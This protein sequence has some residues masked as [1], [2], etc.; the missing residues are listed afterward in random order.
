M[1]VRKLGK[2]KYPIL[3][4]MHLAR[5]STI[6]THVKSM[7]LDTFFLSLVS[8]IVARTG[9][10]VDFVFTLYILITIL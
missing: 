2:G 9:F 7:S 6:S 4:G 10:L 1:T 8:V 5:N 3:R